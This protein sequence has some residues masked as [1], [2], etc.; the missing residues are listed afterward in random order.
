MRKI[1]KKS[2]KMSV[3]A[4]ACTCG[5]CT[6]TSTC[7]SCACA[8]DSVRITNKNNT[9]LSNKQYISDNYYNFQTIHQNGGL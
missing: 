5:G 4:Y 2:S 3:E 8:S 6:C 1:L 7:G 9:Y